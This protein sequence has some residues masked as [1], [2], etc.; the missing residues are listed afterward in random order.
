MFTGIHLNQALVQRQHSQFL[1]QLER[2]VKDDASMHTTTINRYTEKSFP[3]R[4][5][6]TLYV[7]RT[8]ATA[9][10]RLIKATCCI[11]NML[12]AGGNRTKATLRKWTTAQ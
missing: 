7:A 12:G 4:T 1:H 9:N 5:I 2:R 8:A 10:Q 3:S 11:S 6:K